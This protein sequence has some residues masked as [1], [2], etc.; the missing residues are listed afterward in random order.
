MFVDFP[1]PPIDHVE[2]ASLARGISVPRAV[3]SHATRPLPLRVFTQPRPEAAIRN[4]HEA[5]TDTMI[6]PGARV[7][8][9]RCP[10]GAAISPRRGHCVPRQM[11]L[12]PGWIHQS[13][14]V[15]TMQKTAICLALSVLF[16]FRALA[17]PPSDLG[18]EVIESQCRPDSTY[19]LITSRL[20]VPNGWLVRRFER[21]SSV[22]GI[23]LTFVPDPDYKWNP[24]KN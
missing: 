23:G 4:L 22:F 3:E 19:C 11:S 7:E 1:A 8:P 5:V 2:G 20:K 16:T 18:W 6:A 24:P 14:E 17:Q 10:C 12:D 15:A 13:Q 21:Y 9:Q